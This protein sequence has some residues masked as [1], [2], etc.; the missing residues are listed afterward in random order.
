MET[1]KGC[2]EIGLEH[3]MSDADLE[4]VQ[5][6]GGGNFS[7]EGTADPP[8]LSDNQ[9]KEE[10]KEQ[11]KSHADAV[12]EGRH[13]E[14]FVTQSAETRNCAAS[15]LSGLL[16][17]RIGRALPLNMSRTS[18]RSHFNDSSSFNK[19]ASQQNL[20][21]SA[22]PSSPSVTVTRERVYAEKQVEQGTEHDV[23]N[24]TS[25]LL[26]DGKSTVRDRV[27]RGQTRRLASMFETLME[28]ASV[29]M[30]PQRAVAELPSCAR[31][32]KSVPPPKPVR[33][34]G[35]VENA[36]RTTVNEKVADCTFLH[37]LRVTNHGHTDELSSGINCLRGGDDG[38]HV[39]FCTTHQVSRSQYLANGARPGNVRSITSRF[40]SILAEGSDFVSVDSA[41]ASVQDAA[42]ALAVGH[43]LFG[44]PRHRNASFEKDCLRLGLSPRRMPTFEAVD[45]VQGDQTTCARVLGI[46]QCSATHTTV[47]DYYGTHTARDIGY[48]EKNELSEEPMGSL[49][50]EHAHRAGT[51]CAL[52]GK[53]FA[54]TVSFSFFW[55]T[56]AGRAASDETF[57]NWMLLKSRTFHKSGFEYCPSAASVLSSQHLS[58]EG[59][60]RYE[61]QTVVTLLLYSCC[62]LERERLLQSERNTK[63]RAMLSSLPSIS[64]L[65]CK[66]PLLNVASFSGGTSVSAA[67]PS[68]PCGNDR[69]YVPHAR[70]TND[71]LAIQSERLSRTIATMAE[72]RKKSNFSGA[73]V[74][75]C[76]QRELLLWCERDVALRFQLEQLRT[77]QLGKVQ[78][79]LLSPK[80]Q[81]T[82]DID[83]VTV[84]LSR[85]FS[86]TNASR[87]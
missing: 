20:V 51:N 40:E 50:E 7:Q 84:D 41:R 47:R 78:L 67:S 86:V 2:G 64:H 70:Q 59:K 30:T 22:K 25:C 31:H 81:T 24:F 49:R 55:M 57:R 63:N 79:P 69:N 80:L 52:G 38:R 36:Q 8:Q 87:G 15:V 32:C 18:E 56:N 77:L 13:K 48:R 33:C 45:Y 61:I 65:G 1:A 34:D 3:A 27:P 16:Q 14:L 60:F 12:Y 10:H 73:L 26:N 35:D 6:K 5:H 39:D 68:G 46:S 82:L 71:E 42:S 76:A 75:V 74:E 19:S 83:S 43:K 72:C 4:G 66:P 54:H 17:Q 28:A 85:D 21:A 53:S 44:T 58:A 62:A 37:S 23:D 9:W 29:E 11:L